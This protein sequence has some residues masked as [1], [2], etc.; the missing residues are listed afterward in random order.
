[1]SVSESRRLA[2]HKAAKATLGE[3]EGDTLMELSP[4]ANTEI[5][6]MQA[7]QHTEE[8]LS[9]K[10]SADIAATSAESRETAAK[11]RAH[12]WKVVVGTGIALYLAT[13]GTTLG[14]VVL[15]IQLLDLA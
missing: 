2:L 7:L 6:T 8:R 9:A 13:V 11:L 12:T 3:K 15:I 4:P 1:M 14:G 5:A 10:I